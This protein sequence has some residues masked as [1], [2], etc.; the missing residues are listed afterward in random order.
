MIAC[1]NPSVDVRGEENLDSMPNFIMSG[2]A[3]SVEVTSVSQ[4]QMITDIGKEPTIY[5]ISIITEC[6]KSIL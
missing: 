4:K 2:A 1:F 5:P 3:R 6:S